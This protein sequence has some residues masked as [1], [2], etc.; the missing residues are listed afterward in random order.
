ILVDA[1]RSRGA[2]RRGGG[3][4]HVT[5]SAADDAP[6]QHDEGEAFALDEA[7]AALREAAAREDKTEKS[8]VTPGP[9]A[10]AYEMLG[11]MLLELKQPGAA[12]EEFKKTMAKEPNRFRALAGAAAA[13]TA[14]KDAKTTRQ[15]DEQ[16]LKICER[17]DQ[18][19]RPELVAARQA[20]AR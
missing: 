9:L 10:P 13:A 11:E 20:V 15:Y 2:E 3:E 14:L 4:I 18:P 8:A 17:G 16:L 5:L 12:L 19:G 7:L 1:A 6:G